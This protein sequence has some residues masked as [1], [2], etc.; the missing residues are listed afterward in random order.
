V[1]AFKFLA[2]GAVAPFTGFRW[3]IPCA[4]DAGPWVAAPDDRPHHGVH[5]CRPTDLAFWLDAELWRGER[6]AP[7]TA[8]QRHIVARRGRLLERLGGWNEG[9]AR[10][11][12]EAC[13][14][15]ARDRA[16]AALLRDGLASDA[17]PLGRCHALAELRAASDA[18]APRGPLTRA[19]AGYLAE[20]GEFLERGD[21][22]CSAYIS[23]R[24]AVPAEHDEEDAFGA[25][26]EHQ[27]TLL[28]EMLQI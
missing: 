2:P 5:A 3:P 7:V 17:E 26:R 19:L 21:S 11:F 13:L 23:A 1:I 4:S 10:R 9:T 12:A 6:D 28:A 25:E 27:S 16:V 15:R 8:A 14:W 24:S 22:A 18:L 20:A